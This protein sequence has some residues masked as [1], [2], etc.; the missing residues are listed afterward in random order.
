M[1]THQKNSLP[2]LRII[3]LLL[4]AVLLMGLLSGCIKDYS[5]RDVHKYIRQEMGLRKFKIIDGPIEKENDEGYT[6]EWWTVKTDD[7]SFDEPLTF[8]VINHTTYSLWANNYLMNEID[9]QIFKRLSEEYE[10]SDALRMVQTEDYFLSTGTFEATINTRADFEGIFPEIERFQ[11]FVRNYPELL[12]MDFSLHYV[13]N[14]GD[15][16][17]VATPSDN[18]KEISS[19]DESSTTD[20]SSLES[21]EPSEDEY[22]DNRYIEQEYNSPD[23][24]L[25]DTYYS[26]SFNSETTRSDLH[27]KMHEVG[28]YSYQN[29]I[30][31][32]Y[33]A[34][35]LF[36]GIKNRILEFTNDEI[37]NVISW[38]K[39]LIEIRDRNENV[40]VPNLVYATDTNY[41]PIGH[42]YDL[43]KFQNILVSGDWSHYSFTGKDGASYEIGYDLPYIQDSTWPVE[44]CSIPVT[45]ASKMLGI[46]LD[47]GNPTY[48]VVI[49]SEILTEFGMDETQLLSEMDEASEGELWNLSAEADGIHLK[50]KVF[51]FN[52]IEQR[53]DD[54]IWEIRDEMRYFDSGFEFHTDNMNKTYEGISFTFSA[55]SVNIP[56]H[57]DLINEA[58][59]RTIINQILD[60]P[61]EDWQLTLSFNYKVNPK[62][63]EGR[64]IILPAQMDEYKMFLEHGF[65]GEMF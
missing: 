25:R 11:E 63:E 36:Y 34:D 54:R 4:V 27:N 33:L 5:K 21:A 41:I 64:E 49:P 29:G 31:Y 14:T 19:I 37:S 7:Y 32:E 48:E 22:W 42:F 18:N 62:Y 56:A 52:R 39:D 60:N 40:L 24:F 44:D 28:E 8:H 12:E 17:D 15:Q 53:N 38:N 2:L 23:D 9:A 16:E 50:G 46:E 3:S 1:K 58:V 61:E 20:S 26:I 65:E 30:V 59:C 55:D 35:C 51:S 45:D 6:D 43:L 57:K 10:Q 13:V 47:N